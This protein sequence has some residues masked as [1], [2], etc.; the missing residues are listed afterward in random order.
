MADPLNIANVTAQWL[1][2]LITAIGLGSLV[3]QI[4]AYRSLLDP[5]HDN[6]GPACL[7]PWAD[8]DD[9]LRSHLYVKKPTPCGPVITGKYTQGLC[10]L[11]VI[12]VSRKPV[13]R[14]GRAS[15]TKILEIFHPESLNPQ[16]L[17]LEGKLREGSEA[18]SIISMDSSWKRRIPTQ[19]LKKHRDKACTTITR[20]A[21]ITCLVLA[22]AYQIYKHSGAAGLRVAYSGYTGIWELQWPLGGSADV[23]FFPLDSHDPA[24]EMHPRTFKRRVDKCILMLMGVIQGTAVGK[25]GFPEPKDS[26]CSVLEFHKNGFIAHGKTTHLYNMMGGNYYDVD[27]LLRRPFLSGGKAPEQALKLLIPTPE[28]DINRKAIK[29]WDH[30][31]Q[32]SCVYVPEREQHVLAAALDSLPWSPLSWSVHRGMQCLLVAYGAATMNAYR[33][34]LARTLQEAVKDNPKALEAAGW[35]PNFVRDY[36]ADTAAASVAMDGGDSGDSVRIVTA[37][38]LLLW[39]GSEEGLDETGFWRSMV[40]KSSHVEEVDANTLLEPGVVIA[41]TKLFVLE[42]SNEL[43]HKLYEDLPLEMLVA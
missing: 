28:L 39:K 41:L 3:T 34:A 27:Y 19:S 35:K 17:L 30:D 22:N 24:Q 43:D 36:M 38:A 29:P 42:W 40:G 4:G 13:G 18:S 14:V 12:H 10:G 15:W 1:A 6:R 8:N 26:G 25:L 16:P 37:A 33:P 20:T 23:E 9:D 21:F 7:G 5:F 32:S 11:N 31:Q 2:V